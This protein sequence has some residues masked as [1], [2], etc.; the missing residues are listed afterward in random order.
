MYTHGTVTLEKEVAYIA[1]AQ[2]VTYVTL[3]QKVA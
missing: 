2:E 1:L 3:E